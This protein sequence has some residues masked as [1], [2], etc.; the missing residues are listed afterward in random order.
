MELYQITF[1]DGNLTRGLTFEEA[2]RIWTECPDCQTMEVDGYPFD[3]DP[4]N[5]KAQI[6]SGLRHG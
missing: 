3:L 4:E 5:K 1:K 6:R 2:Q